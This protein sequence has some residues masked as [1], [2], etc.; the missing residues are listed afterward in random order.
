M[1]TA[2]DFETYLISGEQPIPKPVCLSYHNALGSGL[3]I[4]FE[5]MREYL[6][7]LLSSSETIIAHNLKFETL[8]IVKHFPELRELVDRKYKNNQFFC[9]LIYEKLLDNVRKKAGFKYG[10]DSLVLKYFKEDISESKNDPDSWRMRYSEL[11]GVPR[12]KWPQEAIDYAIEDSVWAFKVAALQ[13][14]V[15]IDANLSYSAEHYLNLMGLDGIYVDRSRVLELEAE[16]KAKLDPK[17]KA[18]E[19][20]NMAQMQKNG[21]YKKNLKGFRQYIESLNVPLEYTAKGT[22]STSGESL[23]KYLAASN[24][25][26]LQDY[27]DVIKYEKIQTAFVSRLKTA[28]PLI[29]TEYNA[30]V[31]SGRTSS[32]TSTNFPSVNIQQMPREVPNVKWDI[33]NCFVPRPGF[34]IVS[35]DYSGLELSATAHQLLQITGKDDMLNVLNSGKSP[36]DMHSMFAFRVY[37]LKTKDK[38]MTYEKFVANKKK[39]GFKEYRQLAKP[40]NLGFP[41]G[42][43]YDTMRTLLAREGIYPKLEVLEEASNE[44]ALQWKARRFR[45]EGYPVRIRRTEKFKYQLVYDELVSLK[46]ELFDLYPDLGY[47]LREGHKEYLT[48]ETKHIKN[49]FGEWEEEPVYA[50]EVNGFAR[51]WCTYTQFCNGYLMQSPSAIGAKKAMVKIISEYQGSKIMRPLAFIHDEIVFEVAEDMP[52][53]QAV[54]KDVSEIMIDEMQSVLFCARI[55]VEAEAFDYWKKAG[56][57]YEDTYWKDPGNSVLK[58]LI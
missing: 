29:R 30:V 37:K 25:Q 16:L 34:K 42:I 52:T 11:D 19:E 41:G 55:T 2:I 10:L 6:K 44:N 36:V 12:E 56:G 53:I 15:P 43:G 8:A 26:S 28:K 27:L 1:Y 50:F 39:E 22:I 35:I 21:R 45:M 17:Y 24:D 51:D 7:K 33:R 31:S 9:T 4:G 13:R 38:T 23:N 3:I 58:S 48:G 5:E 57:F 40:I 46:Q 54:I 18:L 47:F 49:D 20:K 14:Q 32:R